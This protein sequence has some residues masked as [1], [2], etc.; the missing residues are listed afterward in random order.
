M[1]ASVGPDR[2]KSSFC[3]DFRGSKH[4]LMNSTRSEFVPLA[5][6]EIR[7]PFFPPSSCFAHLNVGTA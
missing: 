2:I 6:N 5:T 1:N 3:V 7:T 4:R